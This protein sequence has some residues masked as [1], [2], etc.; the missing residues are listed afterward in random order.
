MKE[1]AEYQTRKKEDLTSKLVMVNMADDEVS[2]FEHV[3]I[4]WINQSILI[5]LSDFV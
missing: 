3:T 4:H 1:F 2:R 5:N